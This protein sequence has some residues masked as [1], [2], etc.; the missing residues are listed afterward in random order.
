MILSEKQYL[1][2]IESRW[3]HIFH[4]NTVTY[5]REVHA[6]KGQRWLLL[7]ELNV[8]SDQAASFVQDG[9]SS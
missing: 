9:D 2:T 6:Y 3:S 7:A 8:I 4:G 5:M 1:H